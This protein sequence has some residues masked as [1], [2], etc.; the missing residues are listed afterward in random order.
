MTQSGGVPNKVK[1]TATYEIAR[2]WGWGG[3]GSLLSAWVRGG[4]VETESMCQAQLSRPDANGQCKDCP[5]IPSQ[6]LSFFETALGLQA[7]A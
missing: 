7:F 5:L 1:I 3:Q 2:G 4:F 6:E